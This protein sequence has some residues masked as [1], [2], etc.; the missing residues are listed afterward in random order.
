MS[1]QEIA[2]REQRTIN[3]Y[4]LSLD[5]QEVNE[6]D[7]LLIECSKLLDDERIEHNQRAVESDNIKK[8]LQL[9]HSLKFTTQ[10]QIQI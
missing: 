5:D 10:I 7:E 8:L 3:D 6:N 2:D 4:Y 9:G 1:L